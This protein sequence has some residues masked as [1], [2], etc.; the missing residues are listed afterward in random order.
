MCQV[1]LSQ[2]QYGCSNVLS[3]LLRLKSGNSGNFDLIIG[4]L[5]LHF[6]TI[7]EHIHLNLYSNS[8]L[9]KLQPALKTE[10]GQPYTMTVPLYTNKCSTSYL[11]LYLNSGSSAFTEN[12]NN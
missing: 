10:I 11:V 4:H 9:K 7:T 1:L 3:Y 8:A 2:K 6:E 12:V 5:N